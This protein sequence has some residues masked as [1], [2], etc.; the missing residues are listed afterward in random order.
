[1]NELKIFEKNEI[2]QLKNVCKQTSDYTGYFYICE[3]GDKVKIGATQNPYRRYKELSK[4]AEYF[5]RVT[6]GRI[7][8]S[9][10]HDNYY[11][12]EAL[13]HKLFA[14]ARHEG[15]EM[16]NMS[17]EEVI[18]KIPDSLQYWEGKVKVG[19]DMIGLK[20][21][22]KGEVDPKDYVIKEEERFEFDYLD[23]ILARNFP[24]HIAEIAEDYGMDYS[25]F[26][27]ELCDLGVY[28]TVNGDYLV[29]D[30]F[31]LYSEIF[32]APTIKT[33]ISGAK[34][35]GFVQKWTQK[36]QIRLY[37]ILKENG[38]LPMMDREERKELL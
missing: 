13:L 21:F 36:G 24:T 11:Q 23:R 25:D 32:I 28:D 17:L 38:I 6:M 5:G 15:T 26:L 19:G 20:R 30:K 29:S 2:E 35:V 1:M 12:N 27:A 4:Y 31:K 37:E 33:H 22:V 34:T 16:F 8:V 10:P 9:V 3:I 18:D 7:A 14:E